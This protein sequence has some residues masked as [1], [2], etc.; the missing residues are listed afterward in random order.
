MS[1]MEF[2]H[3]EGNDTNVLIMSDLYLS[4]LRST[5]TTFPGWQASEIYADAQLGTRHQLAI[6]WQ[7]EG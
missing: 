4:L 5:M 3:L 1:Y 7:A 2:Y 6:S